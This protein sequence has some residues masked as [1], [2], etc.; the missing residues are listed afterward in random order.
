MYRWS[1]FH[2][3][4][5]NH[6][7]YAQPFGLIVRWIC[8]FSFDY[9]SFFIL[10][11]LS[12]LPIIELE[13]SKY[14]DI[15]ALDS[16]KFRPLLSKSDILDAREMLEDYF[17]L[18]ITDDGLVTGLPILLQNFPLEYFD[19]KSFMVSFMSY[20]T[21][22]WD[23]EEECLFSIAKSLSH[24]FS[25]AVISRLTDTLAFDQIGREYFEVHL[26]PLLRDGNYFYP[27][28]SGITTTS[29]LNRLAD[30]KELY[31]IFERC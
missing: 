29:S 1:Q 21:I 4:D 7:L 26:V 23:D 8:H 16:C 24:A 5:R 18:R 12:C 30:L 9:F 22:N 27:S 20:S 17:S 3:P 31:K 25:A 14:V 2:F 19:A 15:S 13:S 28:K 10:K 6:A 11:N